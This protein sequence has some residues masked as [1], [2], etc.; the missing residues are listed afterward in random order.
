VSRIL[1]LIE[2]LCK[3]GAFLS[4]LCMAGIVLLIIV[5][6]FLRIAFGFS[7]LVS[8]EFSGYLLVGVVVLSLGYTL[9]HRAHIR[10]TLFWDN[11]SRKWQTRLDIAVACTS[12]L[13]TCFALYHSFLLVIDTYSLGITADT[14]VETPLWMP[15]AVIPVG[16]FL[17]LLQLVNFILRGLRS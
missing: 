16:L 5:E 15:Q 7:T 9:Q 13:I 4:A 17:F 8:S 6:I 3:A 12:M 10:I 1:A 2:G 11:L 14:I